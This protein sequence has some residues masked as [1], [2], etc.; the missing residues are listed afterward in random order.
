MCRASLS[1]FLTIRLPSVTVPRRIAPTQRTSSSRRTRPE[2][3]ADVLSDVRAQ[4]VAYKT[5][6]HA[7]NIRSVRLRAIYGRR[8]LAR[9][10]AC[11]CVCV[12]QLYSVRTRMCCYYYYCTRFRA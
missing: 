9:L 10:Q 8:S 5:R 6:V 3:H 12:L 4:D 11:V 1:S 7:Y 2:R